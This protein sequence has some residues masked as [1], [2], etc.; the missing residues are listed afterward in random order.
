MGYLDNT[1]LAHLW[2]KVKAALT[3]HE[4]S[5][6]KHVTAA[7]RTAWNGKQNA[8][9]FDATPTAGSGNPVM[10]GG[11]KTYVDEQKALSLTVTLA[12]ASWDAGTKAQTVSVVGV[13]ADETKQAITPA[14]APGSWEAAGQAGVRCTAQAAGSLTFACAEVPTVDLTYNM[15]IQEVQG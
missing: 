6:T 10:S 5:T 7:E 2:G 1:G 14:P 9:K 4:N 11:V 13:L 12:A 8:L 3:A 15:L